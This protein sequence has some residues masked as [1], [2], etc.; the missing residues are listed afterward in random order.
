VIGCIFSLMLQ[1]L[2]WHQ[3]SQQ[4]LVEGKG[5]QPTNLVCGGFKK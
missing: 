5:V 4:H 2:I 3:L 1:W